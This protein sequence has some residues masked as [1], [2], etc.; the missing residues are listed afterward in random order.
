VS[1]IIGRLK[2]K[3]TTTAQSY[4]F[5]ISLYTVAEAKQWLRRN[6]VKYISFEPAEP[7]K[8]RTQKSEIEKPKIEQV[9]PPENTGKKIVGGK[10]DLKTL[11][12]ENPDAQTEHASA[13]EAKYNAGFAAGR[14]KANARNAMAVKYLGS[15]DYPKAIQDL[16]VDVLKGEKEMAALDAS[17]TVWDSHK[18]AAKSESAK[19]E[20]NAQAETPAGQPAAISEDGMIRNEAD[21]QATIERQK[22]ALGLK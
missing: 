15:A 19:N 5:P 16:A 3:T 1:V 13:L 21:F 10:M 17:V 4:R 2:G 20:T 11:L 14:E 9:K 7:K 18:E 6:R 12:A 8:A 22:T